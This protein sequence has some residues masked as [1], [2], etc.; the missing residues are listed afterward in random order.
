MKPCVLALLALALPAVVST[1]TNPASQAARLWRQQHEHAIVDE[2]VAF[3]KIPNLSTDTGNI[4]RN[5]DALVEMLKRRGI[6]ARQVSVPGSNPVVFGEVRTAGATRTLGFYAHYDGASLDPKE[7]TTPPFE[8]VLRDKAIENGGKLVPMPPAG[9]PFDPESRVYARGAGD[10]KA[11]IQALL[12]ALD[13]MRAAGQTPKANIK[14]AFEGE[15]EADS[16]NL[17]KIL[18]ANRSTFAADLWFVCDAPVHQTRRQSIVFGARGSGALD[19]T[20]YGPRVELHSGHYGAWAPN[21]AQLLAQ[22]LASM[23]SPDG[24]VLVKAFY[25]GVTPLSEI[26]KQAVAEAPAV[27]AALMRE[28]WLGATDNAPRRLAE[29]LNEPTLNVRGI[30]SARIGSQASNVIPTTATASL[31]VR[32]VKGMDLDRTLQR[33]VDHIRAQGYFVVDKEPDAATRMAHPRVA[34]VTIRP[35]GYPGGRTPMDL[36]LSQDV[37]K[38]VESVRGPAIKIPSSGGS[39]PLTIIDNALGTRTIVMPIANHDDNQH[40]FDENLRLQNLWD[41]I[42]L[43]AALLSM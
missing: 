34:L 16:I 13:S 3:L 29:L 39:I 6:E 41:G 35:G 23:K 9:S 12:S 38:T 31:D 37:I 30:S 17:E 5:A 4:R 40:A 42:E 10:D 7:W 2:Y 28:L 15:E 25:D 1:Q 33:V 21:P 27:D 26:E 11:P 20:V 43:M 24:H 22:L 14:F 8:P 19:V 18:V 32:P 36:L